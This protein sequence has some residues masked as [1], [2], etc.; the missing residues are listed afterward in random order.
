M[1]QAARAAT[2]V[3]EQ[4]L[5]S[6]CHEYDQVPTVHSKAAINILHYMHGVPW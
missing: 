6:Q 2:N 4:T 1:N 5:T 3:T